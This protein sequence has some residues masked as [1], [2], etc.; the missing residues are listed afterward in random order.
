MSLATTNS[1][2]FENATET[3]YLINTSKIV[4]GHKITMKDTIR[5]Q[6]IKCRNLSQSKRAKPVVKI[7]DNSV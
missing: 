5:K 1:D 4:K 6:L 2:S 7:E 3:R